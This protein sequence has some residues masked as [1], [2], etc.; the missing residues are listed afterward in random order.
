[1][2]EGRLKKSGGIEEAERLR[3]AQDEQ[4]LREE[5][6]SQ[7]ARK[8]A[9]AKAREEERAK[10]KAAHDAAQSGEAEAVQE[11]AATEADV[12]TSEQQPI[13]D[14]PNGVNTGYPTLKNDVAS[15]RTVAE[16]DLTTIAEPKGEGAM[17]QSSNSKDTPP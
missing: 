7:Q 9:R 10:Q 6:E 13:E 16:E 2:G 11:D 14:G 4:N 12:E 3:I 5:W 17:T 15:T 8:A 1:M